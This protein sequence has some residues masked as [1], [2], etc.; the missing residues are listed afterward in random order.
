MIKSFG[1][2]HM[3]A[4]NYAPQANVSE[5]VNQSILAAIRSYLDIDHREWDLHLCE[6]ECAL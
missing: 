2:N 4:G 3:K 1:I 5:H 6:I